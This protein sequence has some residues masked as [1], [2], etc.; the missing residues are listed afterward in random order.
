M[1]KKPPYVETL[2]SRS[3][4]IATISRC[5]QNQTMCCCCCCCS[6]PVNIFCVGSNPY[7]AWHEGGIWCS[8]KK[9]EFAVVA[10]C[11]GLDVRG[12]LTRAASLVSPSG[13]W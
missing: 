3:P 12:E 11:P 7:T 5:N 2:A 6:V 10:Q 8:L 9:A 13:D 4:P 1:T